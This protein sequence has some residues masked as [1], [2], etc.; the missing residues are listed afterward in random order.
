MRKCDIVPNFLRIFKIEKIELLFSQVCYSQTWSLHHIAN[1]KRQLPPLEHVTLALQAW[2]RGILEKWLNS[3]I[4]FKGP[5]T[6]RQNKGIFELTEYRNKD[7]GLCTDTIQNCFCVVVLH[8]PLLW[9]LSP[10]LPSTGTPGTLQRP[11]R[12]VAPG[13]CWKCHRT[14]ALSFVVVYSQ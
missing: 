1:T 5:L 13:L 4:C 10:S 3:H 6:Y 9:L 8:E 14:P 2:S 11:K 7:A 12:W